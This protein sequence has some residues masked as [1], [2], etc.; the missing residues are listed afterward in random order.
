ML[1]ALMVFGATA[2]SNNFEDEVLGGESLSFTVNIDQTRTALEL[3][4]GVWKTVW[5]GDETLSVT[6]GTNTYAFT[7][8]VEN[9]NTFSCVAAGVTSLLGKGVDVVYNSVINSGAGA[10]GMTLAGHADNFGKGS[11][12]ELAAGNA[13]LKFTSAADVTLHASADIFGDGT[14]RQNSFTAKGTDVLV[15]IYAAETVT[16]SYT[17]GGVQGKA[18][19]LSFVNNKIYSLGT[20]GETTT[21]YFVPND[22]WKSDNAWFAA[23]VWNDNGSYADVKLTDENNDG[24]YECLVAAD[25]TKVV[26]CRMDAAAESFS[27]EKVWTQTAES[28]ISVAPANYFYITGWETGEWH[29]AGYTVP[30]T[31]VTPEQ[32]ELTDAL[33]YLVPN[34][35]WKQDGAWFAA[36]FWNTDNVS[37]SLK[38]TDEDGDGVYQCNVPAGMTGVIFCRMNPEFAEFGWN[39]GDEDTTGAPKHVWS[40]TTDTTVG[41]APNNYFYITGWDAGEWGTKPAELVLALAGSFNDWGDLAMEY[42]NGIYFVK[43]HTLEA[44]AELKIKEYGDTTWSGVNVGAADINYMNPNNHIAVA[45]GGGNIAIT[46]AGTYDIYFDLANLKLY[47]VTAGTADYTTAPLQTE[48]GPE[49]VQEEPEVTNKVVYLKPN[50]NWNQS[51]ARFAAYF[52]NGT[53]NVW[54]SMTATETA[55]I[56]QVNLPEGYDYGCNIIFCRMNPSTTANNWNNKWNQTADLKT[57]TDGTNLYTVAEGAWDKGAGTWSTK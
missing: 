43:N 30:E 32:P 29:E 46:A 24:V 21:F 49:P 48:N 25:M 7:N 54:V 44:Y 52:W 57:P 39:N 33:V 53:G 55:G 14:A 4:E 13:F 27:W 34:A 1:V 37:M 6:D 56:Y 19:E 42:G 2:C 36:Y 23:H 9:K 45:Q 11:T 47:V 17:V 38:L 12:V 50:S 51:N 20:L 41:T 28:T 10:A 16:L 26:F 31:P 5:V 3:A 8:S 18:K 40:Q 35:D 22:G 15:P